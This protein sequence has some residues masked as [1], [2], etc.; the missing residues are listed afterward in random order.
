MNSVIKIFLSFCKPCA[1]AI[2]A[3]GFAVSAAEP[4]P[5]TETFDSAEGFA[6]FFVNN[7]NNDSY[8]WQYNA[9]EKLAEYNFSPDNAADDWLFS[10]AFDLKAGRNYRLSY[11]R[12][13]RNYSARERLAVTIGHDTDPASHR[14]IV[15]GDDHVAEIHPT[16]QKVDFTVAADGSYHI[17][18]HCLSPKDLY[19]VKLDDVMLEEV[20]DIPVPAPVSD[21]S[22]TPAAEGALSA[23]I[24]FSV[25]ATDES[26]APVSD[27]T[28][29]ELYRS[30]TGQAIKVWTGI[31][32][33]DAL[34]FDDTV[35]SPGNYKYSAVVKNKGGKSAET[36]V[37]VYIG[38]DTPRPV[39]GI[40]AKENADHSVT[41]SWNAPDG[42]TGV[43]GGFSPASALLYNIVDGSG[44]EVAAGIAATT[45]T[46]T[47]I[48]YTEY[49]PQQVLAYTVTAVNG[50]LVSSDT[51]SDPVIAGTPYLAPAEESFMFAT[52]TYYP[53]YGQNLFS[54]EGSYWQC[55][56]YGASPRAD[57]R[58]DDAGLITFRSMA[59]PM[60]ATER[61]C[62]PKFDIGNLKHPTVSFYMNHTSGDD[63]DSIGLDVAVDGGEFSQVGDAIA[64]GA[65]NAG[66]QLHT[67]PLNIP[68]G[69]KTIQL[70]LRGTAAQGHNIH[71]DVIRVFDDLVDFT[72]TG[73]EHSA[74]LTP[75][76]E[77]IISG[78][79]LNCGNRTSQ[80]QV[81]VTLNNEEADIDVLAFDA[82]APGEAVEF[83]F[84]I[85][86]PVTKAGNDIVYSLLV[87]NDDDENPANDIASFTA[88]CEMPPYPAV[89]ALKGCADGKTVTL[90]WTP[91][92]PYKD[93]PLTTD[94]FETYEA[95]AI[96]GA[97]PWKFV[98]MDKAYTG[99]NEDA[100]LPYP[101][102][103]AKMAYQVYNPEKAGVD[104]ADSWG[105]DWASYQ[106]AQYLASMYNADN[107][108]NDDWLISP[109]I[110]ADKPVSFMARA[111]TN[112]Y[113][114]E[115][116][117]IYYSAS[118]D[119]IADF[120]LFASE[121][122]PAEW[123]QYTYWLPAEARYFAI[124]HTTPVAYCFMLDN[125]EC[126]HLSS[127]PTLVQPESYNIY[128]D[129]EYI[130]NVTGTS[131]TE[132]APEADK[133]YQY[134]V[135]AVFPQ[136]E[137]G[138]AGVR[139]TTGDNSGISG[140]G[141]RTQAWGGV[142]CI[143]VETSAATACTVCDT[144]GRTVAAAELPEGRSTLAAAPGIYIVR[145]GITILRV[146]VK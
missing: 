131:Y 110:S 121:S 11:K 139:V 132:E 90:E 42:D 82:P 77:Y 51:D 83:S 27:L 53:W 118:S 99:E 122:C 14:Q 28:Q 69:A 127:E 107:S 86:E 18:F 80:K 55:V 125:L 50:S 78:K 126:A 74:R 9:S 36:S 16:E 75:S 72:V 58:D 20:L 52:T 43:N 10:P 91:S 41:I 120:R 71:I 38:P 114:K 115:T 60:G 49:Q 46:D 19:Y 102:A 26:G 108:A 56:T 84:S 105:Q 62:S 35:L 3:S 63:S 39:T 64:L 112:G 32:A 142:G 113:K 97:G 34:V 24:A 13:K 81:S 33:G 140:I 129:N 136:G 134:A 138:A 48:P 144:A 61:F 95:F 106:G 76:Q 31:A 79:L 40:S 123:I 124:R 101:N 145:A 25:P 111:L 92:E 143:V 104:L 133:D 44:R 23:H 30:D 59:A 22:V 15:E 67:F 37:S 66:W 94:G 65:A 12:H 4:L 146:I 17:G 130:A 8:T 88:A 103:T 137:S 128:R 6:R 100:T 87:A 47:E 54:E 29:A 7:A 45:F 117:E 141:A 68:E 1:A 135:S 93:Y 119:N 57:A 70:A 2:V 21:F 89:A 73:I 96:D 109:E 116:I 5:F 98:D 85:I